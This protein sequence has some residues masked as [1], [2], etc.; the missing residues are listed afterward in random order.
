MNKEEE[1]KDHEQE[2]SHQEGKEQ[3]KENHVIFMEEYVIRKGAD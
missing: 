3:G 1:G 2:H